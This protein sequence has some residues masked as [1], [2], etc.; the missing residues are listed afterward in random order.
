MGKE[1]DKKRGRERPGCKTL[2]GLRMETVQAQRV[3]VARPVLTSPPLGI[4]YLPRNILV[5]RVPDRRKKRRPTSDH[6]R[7]HPTTDPRCQTR[8]TKV[9][10]ALDRGK[11]I[12]TGPRVGT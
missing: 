2:G 10:G 9:S 7:P 5:L 1:L 4:P 12:E 3:G 6:N 8:G 11:K